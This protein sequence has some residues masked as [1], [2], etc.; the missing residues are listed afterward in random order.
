MLVDITTI[1]DD[2][3]ADEAGVG[4]FAAKLDRTLDQKRAEGRG[5][6]NR[7]YEC[8]IEH[9]RHLQREAFA[10]GNQVSIGNYAM[11]IWNRE[12]PIG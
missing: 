7:P 10:Q 4:R 11:M 9:L 1:T 8:S 12:H 5:G 3:T 2:K 6:W